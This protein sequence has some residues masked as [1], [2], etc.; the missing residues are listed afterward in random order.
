MGKID[1]MVVSLCLVANLAL[2]LAGYHITLAL[3]YLFG[4]WGAIPSSFLFGGLEIILAYWSA[5]VIKV[6]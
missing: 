1:W 5:I 2:I 6:S 4:L 3:W